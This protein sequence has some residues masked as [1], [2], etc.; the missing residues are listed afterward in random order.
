M[1]EH[2]LAHG[3]TLSNVVL[4]AY[5]VKNGQKGTIANDISGEAQ[6]VATGTF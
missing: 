5:R 2:K 1:V 4:T 6:S 3:R